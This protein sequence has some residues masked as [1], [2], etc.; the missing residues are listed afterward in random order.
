[1]VGAGAVVVVAGQVAVD[2]EVDVSVGGVTRDEVEEDRA[3]TTEAGIAAV[4]AVATGGAPGAAF[5]GARASDGAAH[6]AV[7]AI[8]A[9]AGRPRPLGTIAPV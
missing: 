7:N 2:D 1:M 6:A 5:V 8:N 9:S 3:A 4:A